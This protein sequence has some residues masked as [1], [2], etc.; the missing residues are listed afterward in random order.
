MRAD[1]LLRRL[2]PGFLEGGAQHHIEDLRIHEGAVRHLIR[3]E[4]R[5]RRAAPTVLDVVD[6]R[7]S[8][9]LWQRHA[10]EAFALAADQ[11]RP[12]APVNVIEFD[13]NHFRRAQPETGEEQDHRVVAPPD[14]GRLPCGIDQP[15]DLVRLQRS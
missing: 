7:L 1:V 15:L 4:Q 2:E 10:I 13:R 6:D 5:P 9:I 12:G 11:D 3:E 14:C 8:C